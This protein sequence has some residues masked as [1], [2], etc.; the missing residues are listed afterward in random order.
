MFNG[1]LPDG[2]IFDRRVKALESQVK[3]LNARIDKLEK[4]KSK[5]SKSQDNENE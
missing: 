5:K 2:V 4:S 1:K 3:D